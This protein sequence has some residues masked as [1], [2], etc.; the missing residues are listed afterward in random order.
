MDVDQA[1]LRPET[2]DARYRR[3]GSLGDPLVRQKLLA[4]TLQ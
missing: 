4:C 3:V 1:K 2:L